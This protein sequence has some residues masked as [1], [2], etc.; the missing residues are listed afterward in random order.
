MPIAT[1]T[2][3]L[4]TPDDRAEFNRWR[5][6]FFIVL[7]CII[8]IALAAFSQQTPAKASIRP[9]GPLPGINIP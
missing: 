3:Y 6:G 5:L 2:R 8:L 7:A 4:A 9:T 1:G